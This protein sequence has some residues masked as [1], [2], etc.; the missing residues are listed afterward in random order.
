[1][2]IQGSVALITGGGN[3]IGAAIA[4]YLAARGAK[5]VIV[6]RSE[7]LAQ[8][9]AQAIVASGGQAIAVSADVTKEEDTAV[10]VAKALETYGQ[11]NIVVT[12]AG[13]IRDGLTISPDKET[14]KVTRKLGLDKWQQVI[15]VNLT[16]TF[17]TMRDA[18]EAMANGGWPGLLVGI[19]S[20]NKVGQV[21]QIN[22]ASTKA[23]VALMP[24]ILVGEFMLKGIRNIRAVSIAPGYAATSLLQGMNQEALAAI[25]KDVHLGRLVEPDEIAALIAHCA[26][27]EAINATTLEITG[28]LCYPHAVAK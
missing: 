23:A 10:F 17:L 11:L 28:G 25:L 5:I 8:A 12:C 22:Y 7:E 6:D 2:Q 19:S 9:S 20:V 26:E 3:G 1:M 18:A 21:G 16:G 27:N 15:D 4:K 13:I 24:K 14:K